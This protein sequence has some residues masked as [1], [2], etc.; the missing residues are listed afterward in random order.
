MTGGQADANT[1]NKDKKDKDKPTTAN[2]QSTRETHD[3]MDREEKF[4]SQ[5]G[6]QT[7][8]VTNLDYD[9]DCVDEALS[10]NF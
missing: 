8:T 5:A 1:L 4:E 10:F 2:T 9:I 7:F 3:N 6:S